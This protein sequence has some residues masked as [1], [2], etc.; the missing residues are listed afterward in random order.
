MNDA[1]AFVD[2]AESVKKKAYAEEGIITK[3]KE[4]RS[5]LKHDLGMK[6]RKLKHIKPTANSI[7]NLV[8]R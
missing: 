3:E 4:V 5:V 6:F 8:M 2:S 1:D 7:K